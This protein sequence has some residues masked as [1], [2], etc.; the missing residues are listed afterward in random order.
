MLIQM[1]AGQACTQSGSC[2]AAAPAAYPPPH[3]NKIKKPIDFEET[4]T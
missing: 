2:W 4:M 3:Q 1:G